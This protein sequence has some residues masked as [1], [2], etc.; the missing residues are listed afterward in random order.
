MAMS[1]L[2]EAMF[3]KWGTTSDL[4][5]W[6]AADVLPHCRRILMCP[7][8]SAPRH[9]FGD[10]LHRAP[11]DMRQA[12]TTEYSRAEM[13]FA[14]RV[15]ASEA[16]SAAAELVGRQ[17]MVNVFAILRPVAF[18]ADATA[19][20]FKCHKRCRVHGPAAMN[21]QALRV[22]VAG[23]TC[24]SWS[25]IELGGA[26][27]PPV[28]WRLLCGRLKRWRNVL[29]HCCTSAP[30]ILTF[31]CWSLSSANIIRWHRTCVHR[32][33][34]DTQRPDLGATLFCCSD[35]GWN[36]PSDSTMRVLEGCSSG[37][38]SQLVISF[39]VH[40]RNK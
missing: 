25:R 4:C 15:A 2:S 35:G 22:H 3:L 10:I 34:W 30:R 13:E 14:A 33:T 12:L 24:T 17:M 40:R 38:V 27:L 8:R 16:E 7:N 36:P 18:S 37:I 39:G 29:M 32:S 11:R 21:K 23:S 9:V 19:W 20:C 1:L 28:R 26:G 6:R 5:F 31:P